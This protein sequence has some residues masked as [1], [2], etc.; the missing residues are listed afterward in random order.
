MKSKTYYHLVLDASGSMN[1]VRNSTIE[2]VNQQVKSIRALAEKHPDQE[3]SISLT[4]FNTTARCLFADFSPKKAPY[5][6]KKEYNPEGG[7]ALLDALGTRITETEHKLR[8]EDDV[9]LVVVTDGEENS[10]QY[11][12]FPQIANTIER[13]KK[14]ERWSFSFIGADMDAWS[15]ASKLNFSR[16]EVIHADKQAMKSTFLRLDE[17]LDQYMDRKAIGSKLGSLYGN[18]EN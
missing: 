1:P 11:F 2:A 7:T 10:S 8:L 14:T 12:T 17:E 3:I 15:I 4:L 6:G 18:K 16:D 5:I 9:V 13:L